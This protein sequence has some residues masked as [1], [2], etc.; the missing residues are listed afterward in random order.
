MA[1]SIK[2]PEVERLAREIAQRRRV[3]ITEAIRQ[4][5]ERD[6]DRERKRSEEDRQELLQRLI[7]IA[8][9]AAAIPDISDRTEDEILGYDEFGI[10]TQPR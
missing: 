9:S 3:S 4:S 5:L 6:S 8:E 10:P 1:L 2:N 7:A